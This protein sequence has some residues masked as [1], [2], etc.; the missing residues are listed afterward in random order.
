M[1]EHLHGPDQDRWQALMD[2][3]GHDVSMRRAFADR[4]T[5]TDRDKS[6]Q[7]SW[8]KTILLAEDWRLV[9][10]RQHREEVRDLALLV[11][12][13]ADVRWLAQSRGIDVPVNL[14]VEPPLSRAAC[15]LRQPVTEL[16]WELF[17]L[18]P[19]R[20]AS[21]PFEPQLGYPA[22]RVSSADMLGID[23]DDY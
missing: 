20:Q 19:E 4:L 8:A 21:P 12:D 17:D 1:L 11:R 13:R 10:E 7:A 6:G 14:T 16:I 9:L 5:E 23:D 2:T 15:L 18:P 3:I 22:S